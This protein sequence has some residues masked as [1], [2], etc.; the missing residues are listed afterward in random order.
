MKFQSAP[1]NDHES[2]VH[3]H[4]LSGVYGKNLQKSQ[5]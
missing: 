5:F 2:H 4:I 1:E 3:G